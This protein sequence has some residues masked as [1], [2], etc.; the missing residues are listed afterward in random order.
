MSNLES[1]I[2]G[3]TVEILELWR[4][5]A[6]RAASARGLPLPELDNLM[7]TYLRSLADERGGVAG[8][9][10]R[11]LVERHFSTRLHQGFHLAEITEEFALLGRCISRVWNDVSP[12]E[13]MDAADAERLFSE[14]Q[15]A[16]VAITDMFVA[17]MRED[18]QTDKRTS[19]RLEAIAQSAFRNDSEGWPAR[20]HE[21][22]GL[23][24]EAMGADTA[25]LL[26]YSPED[27]QLVAAASSGVANELV[28][29][30]TTSL[31]PSS[32]AGRVAASEEGPTELANAQSTQ[33]EVSPALRRSGVH[34]LLGVRLP[35][36][37]S[38][39]G[40]VYVGLRE[41]R[42]F[43]ERE[44]RRLELLGERLTLH[45]DNARLNADLR[46]TV[47]ALR[48]ER[49]LRERFVSL[50]AHDLRGPL[51]AAKLS[52]QLLERNP[53]SPK[54]RHE[55][56]ERIVAAIDRSER[57]VRNLLD[58]NYV[59]A[60]Q[61]LPL[62]L[63]RCDLGEV[64][65]QVVAEL[66]P[67]H[68][69]RFL[70]DVDDN[71]RGVWDA[72]ELRRALWNLVTNAVKHGAKDTPITVRVTRRPKGVEA[73]VHNYGPPLSRETRA[74]LFEPFAQRSPATG[75]GARGWGLGLTLVKA[76]AEAHGG[77]VEVQSDAERGT[78]FTLH[79]PLD[80]R[81]SQ[82]ERPPE[83]PAWRSLP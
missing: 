67:A 22:L 81:P 45:I 82:G 12:D 36:R 60:G 39:I 7:P 83:E 46:R 56:A 54:Q 10:Q 49:T 62:H 33:L 19:C 78:T 13:P 55:L 15:R 40:I 24:Q 17:H 38:L 23:I 20:L 6:Q 43:A 31:G 69:G 80:A 73:S 28:E 32:F 25:T 37:R 3:H 11:L 26:L 16:A 4:A 65:R 27:E 42:P 44:I 63:E 52:A 61:K 53:E 1:F 21:F 47:E 72:S 29:A 59:Q 5:D 2:A 66:E 58:A 64:A 75:D 68:G 30:Y 34:S 79:L 48:D 8:A 18:E 74:H 50:L 51:S 41:A 9:R 76:C 14:L 70:L 57:M 77:R 35:T 71:A